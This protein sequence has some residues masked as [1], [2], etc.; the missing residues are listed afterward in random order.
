MGPV[1]EDTVEHSAAA[2]QYWKGRSG[3]WERAR[4]VMAG[5]TRTGP[6][7][8]THLQLLWLTAP[9][10]TRQTGQAH[11]NTGQSRL[12]LTQI[13][14]KHCTL[15][16]I[17]DPPNM[18]ALD[19]SDS[20]SEA[21]FDTPAARKNKKNAQRASAD[22][23][24]G[25][26]EGAA[27]G[28]ARAKESHYTTEEAREAALRRELE[29]IR[30]VNKVIEGVV[31]SLQKAK[32]NMEV[33]IIVVVASDIAD[34]KL[35]RLQNCPERFYFAPNMDTHFIPDRAQPTTNSEP[36]MARCI[37]RSSRS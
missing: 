30:N 34:Y 2:D 17:M 32:D 18:D 12:Q 15:H 31:D 14:L 8:P 27:G 22:A 37:P 3:N 19:L 6:K 33:S 21:L 35:D 1:N 13:I 7:H 28:K 25:A 23:G 9:H 5:S 11:V 4:L 36:A 20:D 24:E 29:S 10:Q 26:G 16:L